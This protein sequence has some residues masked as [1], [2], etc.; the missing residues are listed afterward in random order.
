MSRFATLLLLLL[1]VSAPALAGGP[2]DDRPAP[3]PAYDVTE[4]APLGVYVHGD[5]VA[6]RWETLDPTVEHGEVRVSVLCPGEDP[7][8][9]FPSTV[10]D[11][12]VLVTLPESLG[13]HGAVDD[14]SDGCVVE[15]ANVADPTRAATSAPFV[16]RAGP[17]VGGVLTRKLKRAT[18][19]SP[20]RYG[21]GDAVVWYW[22][23]ASIPA[24][25]T[26]RASLVCDGREEWVRRPSTENDGRTG[27]RLPADFGAFE[28]CRAQVASAQDPT[29]FARTEAFEVLDEPLPSLAVTAPEGGDALAMGTDVEVTWETEAVAPDAFVKLVLRDL[30]GG[31]PNRQLGRTTNTGSFVWSVPTDLSPT[32]AY[33]LVVLADAAEGARLVERVD[34]L[35][36][37]APPSPE[38]VAGTVVQWGASTGNL[39]DGLDGVVAVDGGLNHSYAVLEDGTVEGWGDNFLTEITEPS[40]LDDIVDIALTERKSFA[41]RANGTVEDW[42][43]IGGNPPWDLSG[44]VD[45]VAN[46]HSVLA[47]KGDG[48]VVGWGSSNGAAVPEGLGSVVAVAAGNRHSLALKADGTIVG[49]GETDLGATTPPEGLS[50]VVALAAGYKFSLALKS[51]GTVV[52][53]GANADGQATPPEGLSGV[54]AIAAGYEHALALKSDGTVVGWGRNHKGQASPPSGLTDVVAIAAGMYHSLAITTAEPAT[55][56]APA[57]SAVE[58]APDALALEAPYPNPTHGRATV[59]L[60]L[61]TSAPVRLE[62]FDVRGRRVAVLA[63]DERPAGWHDLAVETDGLAPGVYVVRMAAA[64]EVLTRTLTVVR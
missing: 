5:D 2:P 49:W 55:M 57:A 63:E 58:A 25:H 42:G 24:G 45:I 11:G 64:G 47:L 16:V 18:R 61:P 3:G 48:T 46:E 1:A 33:R 36:F 53:W 29:L 51:D 22:D 12:R 60:G 59:R 43:G 23:T 32:A 30:D 9:R 40:G 37:T 44:V 27:G 39:P 50:D 56:R 35:T 28:T 62:V 6:V 34:P 10:N 13:E 52:G 31:G 4:P 21:L 38:P 41:L 14:A 17:A 19:R 54:V 20:A 26:V 15:V 8:V 7:Y